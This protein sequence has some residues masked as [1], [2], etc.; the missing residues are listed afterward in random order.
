MLPK[1]Y[2]KQ[3][4]M[5]TN[6]EWRDSEDNNVAALSDKVS[7]QIILIQSITETTVPKLVA[8]DVPPVTG[9]VSN[10]C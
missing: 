1:N 4:R 9:E 6:D 8:D 10:G 7:E 3:K 2:A 5:W